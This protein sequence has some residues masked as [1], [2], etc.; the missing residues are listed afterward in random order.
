MYRVVAGSRFI[1]AGVLYGFVL[2]R[3]YH[4]NCLAP[5]IKPDA[6]PDEEEDWFCWQCECLTDCLE[7]LEGEFQVSFVQRVC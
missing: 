2:P 1:A 7:M 4:Q 6:F 5:A 3:A